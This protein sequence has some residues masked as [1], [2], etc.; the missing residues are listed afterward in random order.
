MERHDCHFKGSRRTYANQLTK[1]CLSIFFFASTWGPAAWVIIGETFP[2]PIRS[3]GVGLS[4]ASNWLWNC[5]LAVISPYFV[6]EKYGN[7]GAKVFFIW[8]GLCTCA[9]V[10]AYFL[11]PETK[12]LTLEQLDKMME[13]TTPRTSAKWKPT[14]TFASEMGMTATG[15]LKGST[16]QDEVERKGSAYKS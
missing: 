16:V 13:E 4:T 3:R 11:V 12:G 2:L 10:F 1:I 7:L 8:G 5:I 9:C 15:E 6:G 14:T